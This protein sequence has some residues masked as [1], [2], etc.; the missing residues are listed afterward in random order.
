MHAEEH[1]CLPWSY[2]KGLAIGKAVTFHI[3]HQVHVTIGPVDID[4]NPVTYVESWYV[5]KAQV[6]LHFP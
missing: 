1:W 2:D 4:K 6:F 3:C 5:A